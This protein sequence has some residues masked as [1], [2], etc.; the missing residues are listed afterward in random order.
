[1]TH[2]MCMDIFVFLQM[3]FAQVVKAG[4]S[5]NDTILFTK[6]RQNSGSTSIISR[7]D[8]LSWNATHA[9]RAAIIKSKY[10]WPIVVLPVVK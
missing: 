2:E 5:I 7:R 8:K 9:N 1:M 10:H 6:Q 3:L 4:K